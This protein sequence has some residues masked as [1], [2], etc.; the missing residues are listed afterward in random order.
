MMTNL[1]DFD[2][3]T[4]E[5]LPDVEHNFASPAVFRAATPAVAEV[6]KL[7]GSGD[8]VK[9]NKSD[10]KASGGKDAT[11]QKDGG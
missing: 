1:R 2:D 4:V 10:T 6:K 5:A 7:A 3:V 8:S 11:K 9:D